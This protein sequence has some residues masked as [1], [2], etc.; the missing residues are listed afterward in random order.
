MSSDTLSAASTFLANALWQIAL[1][2]ALAALANSGL[3]RMPA[4]HRFIL[5]AIGLGL[6]LVLPASTIP[7]FH[8]DT[9]AELASVP[10]SPRSGPAPDGFVL[11]SDVAHGLLLLYL[12]SVIAFTSRLALALTRAFRT[13]SRARSRP[14][15]KAVDAALLRLSAPET[16]VLWS[17][18]TGPA[19]IGCTIILPDR[20]YDESSTSFWLAV[21]G[22]EVAHVRRRDFAWNVVFEAVSIPIGFHPAARWLKRRLDES[23]ELA[24]DES[25][26]GHHLDSK[27]YARSLVDIAGRVAAGGRLEQAMA[28]SNGRFLEGRIMWLLSRERER[29]GGLSLWSGLL[30]LFVAGSV[31]AWLSVSVR[32]SGPDAKPIR[33]GEVEVET[34][35]FD[36]TD[37]GASQP[38]RSGTNRDPF[39]APTAEIR[40]VRIE[41][42]GGFD[43]ESLELRGIVET[44]KGFRAMVTGPDRKAYFLSGGERFYNGEL[45]RIG[46]DALAFRVRDR[47]PLRR[48]L[49]RDVLLPL[50]PSQRN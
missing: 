44:P 33:T 17:R 26:T 32:A 22:H 35:D 41:G 37:S 48:D 7:E 3:E 13:R 39:L 5:L 45:V 11:R 49:E 23:R 8:S 14:L 27:S 16:P 47:D 31:M 36:E 25:V 21:L 15:P 34:I 20:L 10:A 43:I 50:H 30:G 24:C 29:R 46:S 18:S 28:V 38:Y 2:A 42:I 40:P 1:I 4:R 12:A 9:R 19:T 6:C